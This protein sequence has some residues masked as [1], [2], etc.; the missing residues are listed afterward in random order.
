MGIIQ[1]ILQVSY[2]VNLSS[3]TLSIFTHIL[4]KRTIVL[5]L[6]KYSLADS[7][8]EIKL[9]IYIIYNWWYILHNNFVIS[10]S[11]H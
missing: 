8:V 1:D 7:L 10:Q 9:H 3:S 11:V 4:F 6:I 2:F 5:S